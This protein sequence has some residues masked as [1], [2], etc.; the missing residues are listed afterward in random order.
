MGF[1]PIFRWQI[2][3]A[4]LAQN[5]VNVIQVLI[6]NEIMVGAKHFYPNEINGCQSFFYQVMGGR[7]DEGKGEFHIGIHPQGR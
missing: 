7:F 1:K 4:K 6:A 2:K 3:S 5:T